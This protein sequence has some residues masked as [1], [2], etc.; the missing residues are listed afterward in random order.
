M[1]EP[2]LTDCR[3]TLARWGRKFVAGALLLWPATGAAQTITNNVAGPLD[4]N[5]MMQVVHPQQQPD[6]AT[7]LCRYGDPGCIPFNR[8]ACAPQRDVPLE[9][10]FSRGIGGTVSGTVGTVRAYA[11]LQNYPGLC[12]TPTIQITGNAN[13]TTGTGIWGLPGQG[14]GSPQG[15]LNPLTTASAFL[16]GTL[17]VNLPYDFQSAPLRLSELMR[18]FPEVCAEGV[19]LSRYKL[20]VGISAGGSPSINNA[21]NNPAGSAT[22]D[23][24]AGFEFPVDTVPPP[25]PGVPVTTSKVGRVEGTVQYDLIDVD[26]YQVV[27]RT[28]ADAN[29]LAR[30]SVDCSSWTNGRSQVFGTADQSG[31]IAFNVAGANGAPIG[32]CAQ[33]VDFVGNP[34]PYSAAVVA[35]PHDESDLFTA[36]PPTVPLEVGYCGAGAG[37]QVAGIFGLLAAAASRRRRRRHRVGNAGTWLFSAALLCLPAGAAASE[38]ASLGGTSRPV[39]QQNYAKAAVGVSLG[40]QRPRLSGAAEVQAVRNAVSDTRAFFARPL[41]YQLRVDAFLQRG[42]GLLGPYLQVGYGVDAAPS[43]LCTDAAGAAIR[44]TSTTI[45][46]SQRGND[47]AKFTLLPLGIGAVYHVDALRRL[48][49]FP[50]VFIARAGVDARLWW[51]SV[52][53]TRAQVGGDPRRPA[54]GVALG[55]SGSLALALGLDQFVPRRQ[56]YGHDRNSRDTLLTL[57]Y[58]VAFA[59]RPFNSAARLDLSDMQQVSLGLSVGFH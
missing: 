56:P 48:Y 20:C 43:R 5:M 46:T 54:R 41:L 13:L 36:W 21:S 55:T 51:A 37:G 53:S 35:M 38:F 14:L 59:G 19:Q 25:T 10:L 44:C 33:T 4:T 16:G 15:A 2:S 3:T 31:R 39:P 7:L 58:A 22:A 26:V 57:E 11:W 50:L 29:D 1:T 12:Y 27:L 49:D 23:L 52:G 34:S 6:G 24:A 18:A 47:R 30:S 8:A 28:T 45:L 40:L 32:F 42:F 9:I 17:A